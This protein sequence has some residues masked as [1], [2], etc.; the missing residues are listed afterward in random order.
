MRRVPKSR[1][2]GSSVGSAGA[3]GAVPGTKTS[4]GAIGTGTGKL[5]ARGEPAICGLACFDLT[6]AAVAGLCERRKVRQCRLMPRL[7]SV[8]ERVRGQVTGEEPTSLTATGIGCVR[9][10]RTA[11]LLGRSRNPSSTSPGLQVVA[12]RRS[13]QS[14]ICS[15]FAAFFFVFHERAC[16]PKLC[17]FARLGS[18]RPKHETLQ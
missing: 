14:T 17:A 12:T 8:S 11:R 18:R 9:S 6:I 13:F 5:G 16:E 7:R 1:P 4:R 10:W 15:T 2:S 3:A